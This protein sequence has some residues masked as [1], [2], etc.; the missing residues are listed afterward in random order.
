MDFSIEASSELFD[1]LFIEFILYFTS[2]VCMGAYDIVYFG[3]VSETLV[4]Y[5]LLLSQLVVF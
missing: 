3:N 4:H 2:Y 5:R 1:G